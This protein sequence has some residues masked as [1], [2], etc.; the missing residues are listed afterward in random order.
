MTRHIPKERTIEWDDCRLA[1]ERSIYIDYSGD[2]YIYLLLLLRFRV[3][4]S[5]LVT[6][7]YVRD[8]LQLN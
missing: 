5:V 1:V 8:Q 2:P 7:R 3:I 6:L 4:G